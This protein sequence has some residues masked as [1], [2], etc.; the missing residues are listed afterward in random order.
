MT[1]QGLGIAPR[2]AGAHLRA[3][4]PRRHRALAGDRRHRARPGDR[5]ARRRQPRRHVSVWSAARPGVDLHH[6]LPAASRRRAATRARPP[7]EPGPRRPTAPTEPRPHRASPTDRARD[8]STRRRPPEPGGPPLSRILI[9]EDEVSFS[10]PLSYVLRKEGYD[11]AVAETGPD[12]LAEFDKNG[13][14]LV[15]LDLMLPGLSGID[16][17]RA[18]RQRSVGAGHHADRQ[19][20][21]DRQGR[22]PRDRRRR[23]RHQA[24]L[25]PGA[26]RPRQG[27][28][29][30]PRRAG[31]A[32]PVDARGRSGADGRRAPHRQRPGRR[33]RCRSRSSSCS[34][35]CCAT[36]AGC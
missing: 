9:V 19:G 29:A 11:V 26:A 25:E 35:C 21:R 14:D 24:L 31:G 22:R 8:P 2:R 30:P 5:Q 7:S 13:A 4:L 18:L 23:L 36:P 3:L 12:G 6:R 33:R 34:R 17:C 1:D 28:A 32:A 10:D 20:Q 15:L 16:V 27:R